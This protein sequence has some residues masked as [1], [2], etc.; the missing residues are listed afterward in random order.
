MK[1]KTTRA[2]AKELIEER[3]ARAGLFVQKVEADGA[4]FTSEFSRFKREL[5]KWR[6]FNEDLLKQLYEGDVPRKNWTARSCC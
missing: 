3:I 2:R 4:D 5:D 6:S 1:L